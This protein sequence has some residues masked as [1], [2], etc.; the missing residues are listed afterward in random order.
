MKLLICTQTID[1][2]DSH[3]GFFA[4]W[5]EEFSKHCEKVAVICLRN[6]GRTVADNVKVYEIGKDA[7]GMQKA[8]RLVSLAWRLRKEYN[9]VF[10]HMNPEYIVVAG[11]FWRLMHKRIALWY[12]HKSVNLKLRIAVLLANIIFTASK[13]S[14][15]LKSNKVCVMGHGIDTNFFS[16]DQIVARGDWILSVGRL[17]PSKRHDLAIRFALQ[18]GKELRI[19]GEGPERTSLETLAKK[20]GASVQFL[21]G[22]SQLRLREEYRKAAYLIHTS[23]TGSL[24]KVVL[25]ALACGLHVRTNDPALKALENAS[26]EYVRAHHSL[27]SLI[28]AVLNSIRTV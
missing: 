1:S 14:F 8:V 12:T 17:M 27:Q 19:A 5:L 20:L 21:G 15:R 26:P 28:I 9:A 22:I 18:E 13:E 10:V 4:R 3:L 16:P 6:G 11:V 24:D 2:R 7:G 25:E 23:E